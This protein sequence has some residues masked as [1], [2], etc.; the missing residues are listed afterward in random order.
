MFNLHVAN[1]TG[2]VAQSGR[3]P[4]RTS[5]RALS[6]SLGCLYLLV[7]SKYYSNRRETSWSASSGWRAPDDAPARVLG[8]YIQ[9]RDWSLL[10]GALTG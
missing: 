10:V 3:A 4:S 6:Q 5:C 1:R 7:C 8:V 9:A 2:I